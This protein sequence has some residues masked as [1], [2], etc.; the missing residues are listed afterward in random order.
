MKRVAVLGATG[1]SGIELL[2]ILSQHKHVIVEAIS[3]DKNAGL[4]IG[5]VVP[6]LRNIYNLTCQTID[7]LKGRS[8]D[9]VFLALPPEQSVS[10]CESF[11]RSG[12]IVID[13]SAAFRLKDPGVFKKWYGFETVPDLLKISEYG[14]P[15]INRERLKHAKLIANPGCYPTGAVIPLIPFLKKGVIKHRGIIIDAKSGVTGAGRSPSQE[16]HFSEVNEGFRAYKPVSHRHI[17]EIEQALSDV[18][19]GI[20]IVF[21]PHLIPTNRGIFTTIYAVLQDSNIT[22][23]ELENILEE[24]Y[25]DEPFVRIVKAPEL[26]NINAVEGSNFVDIAVRLDE[27]NSMIVIFSVIDNLVKGAAGQA[28]QNMNIAL[29]IDET[30]ALTAPPIFP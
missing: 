25:K 3:A 23:A 4:K 26:P 16:L 20:S 18:V 13:I 17:P 5:G 10:V 7:Q 19:N 9:V 14:L 12:A 2:R 30:T 22:T 29:G 8:F 15:E 6:S 27:K 21:V 11:L 28:I 1:Y 24:A